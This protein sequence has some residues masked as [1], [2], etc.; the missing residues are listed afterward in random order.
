M[1]Y[2]SGGN[3]LSSANGK[4]KHSEKFLIFWEIELPGPKLKR[5]LIFQEMQL[6]YIFSKQAFSDLLE[7][8]TL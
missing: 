6:P 2:I 3:F 8:K 7:N 4:K 5:L 1:S